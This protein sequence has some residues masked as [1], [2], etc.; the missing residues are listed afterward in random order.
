MCACSRLGER[1]ERK[2]ICKFSGTFQDYRRWAVRPDT[3][4][5]LYSTE[6]ITP[7]QK[8]YACFGSVLLAGLINF[9][10]TFSLYMH[11]NQSDTKRICFHLRSESL[12]SVLCIGYYILS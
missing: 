7:F 12:P 5:V 6:P 2:E 1:K 4:V 11:Y 8:I 9:L 3:S 10:L